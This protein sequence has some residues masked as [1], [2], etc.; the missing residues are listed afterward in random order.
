MPVTFTYMIEED[1][2][3]HYDRIFNTLENRLGVKI[4]KLSFYKTPAP[5]GEGM[6][7]IVVH[8]SLEEY[9]KTEKGDEVDSWYNPEMKAYLGDFDVNFK[10]PCINCNKDYV[11]KLSKFFDDETAPKRLACKKCW[12]KTQNCFQTTDCSCWKCKMLQR[13]ESTIL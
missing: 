6:N 8:L 7:A 1:L 11:L 10:I 4:D 12:T 3:E 9:I 2:N 5:L 13:E